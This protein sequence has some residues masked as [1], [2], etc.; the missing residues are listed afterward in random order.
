MHDASHP[1][2]AHGTVIWWPGTVRWWGGG[3]VPGVDE[4]LPL[5]ALGPAE[6]LLMER[7]EQDPAFS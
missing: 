2:A 5:S 6:R 7:R 4:P 1:S 3:M